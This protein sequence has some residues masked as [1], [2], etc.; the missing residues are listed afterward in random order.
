MTIENIR[1]DNEFT[2]AFD[3][4]RVLILKDNAVIAKNPLGSSALIWAACRIEE[5]RAATTGRH[6]IAAATDPTALL[7]EDVEDGKYTIVEGDWGISLL[8]HGQRWIDESQLELQDLW[9]AVGRELRELRT[10]TD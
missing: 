10:T 4:G 9:Q 1:I 5:L 7:N 3:D 6:T 2:Y 8:R